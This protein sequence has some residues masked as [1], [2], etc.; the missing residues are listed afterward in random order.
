LFG[1]ATLN[2]ALG[3]AWLQAKHLP[4]R[5]SEIPT[6]VLGHPSVGPQ[7][8]FTAANT[9]LQLHFG[10]RLHFSDQTFDRCFLF[11]L[12]LL[13]PL[14]IV[15][16]TSCHVLNHHIVLSL[17]VCAFPMS[18]YKQFRLISCASALI[19]KPLPNLPA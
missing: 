2:K 5:A 8:D 6:W 3:E 15:L 9:C 17:L 10:T 12:P 18:S 19:R 14:F 1:D 11:L 13:H 7:A 16:S 4:M